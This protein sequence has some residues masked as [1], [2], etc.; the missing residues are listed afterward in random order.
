MDLSPISGIMMDQSLWQKYD[1][2]TA[3]LSSCE[4]LIVAFSGGTDSTLLVFA[5]H[6]T[7]KQNVLAV[8][9]VSPI[10]GAEQTAYARSLAE[11]LGIAHVEIE[12]DEMNLPEFV[13]NTAARCY[14]CKK[15]LF[16]K[17]FALGGKLGIQK[18]AHGANTDDSN[19]FRPGLRAAA[20]LGVIAPL[21]EAGLNKAEIRV[22]SKEMNLPTWNKP[23]DA[24]LAT[25][26][27][28]GA[29]ITT[30][31][32]GR[33]ESAENLLR[34]MGMDGCR[35]RHHGQV[36][37]IETDVQNFRRLLDEP[38]RARIIAEFRSLGFLH[39]ALD[40][41]GYVSGAMNRGLS[42]EDTR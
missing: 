38:V 8:T 39:I 4:R 11:D 26:I 40:L 1:R 25:R 36:A 23:A 35:V 31:A 42:F 2:L 33:I 20:E 12:S 14:V 27:P 37:R 22:L 18:V 32:L 21:M 16:E 5:A 19:D 34:G 13:A 30:D 3:V 6:Q 10:H 17:L 28:F 24:C 29:P 41:E 7:L 9:A 15:N